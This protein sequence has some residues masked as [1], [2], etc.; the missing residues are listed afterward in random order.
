MLSNRKKRHHEPE[1]DP[2]EADLPA[3]ADAASSPQTTESLRAED[4][5]SREGS[6]FGSGREPSAEELSELRAEAARSEE[7][8]AQLQRTT[9]DLKNLQKRLLRE[10]ENARKLAIRNLLQSLLPCCDNL[11]RALQSPESTAETLLD[12]VRLTYDAMQRVIADQGAQAIDPEPGTVLD[13]NVHE[14][15][16]RIPSP[17]VPENAIAQVLE[18]GY[19]L[20]ELVIRPARVTVSAGEPEDP[21]GVSSRGEE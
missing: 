6:E 19:V 4:H 5:G 3:D 2:Q 14:A 21:T 8:F 1:L 9:A 10:K 15:V 20:G 17:G 13:P 18:R 16:V 11:E 12:G 7:L